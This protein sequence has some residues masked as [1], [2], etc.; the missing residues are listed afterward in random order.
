MRSLM[1]MAA[2]AAA[3]LLVAAGCGGM[4]AYEEANQGANGT[5][6]EEEVQVGQETQ[7]L[8]SGWPVPS[9]SPLARST[10]AL[11]NCTGVIVGKRDVITAAHCR[12]AAGT[13]VMFY[14]GPE[15]TGTT[16]VARWVSFRPGVNPASGDYTDSNGKF[17]DIAYL[18]L[19][20]D[21]PAGT[22]PARLPLSYPGNNAYGYRVGVGLHRGYNPTRTMHYD[23]GRTYSSHINDGHF[24]LNESDTNNGDSGG[25]FY[26]WASNGASW[27]FEVQGVLYGKVWE[28][29]YRN[30]YTSTRHH[31]S[32]LN[33]L[34]YWDWTNYVIW[35]TGEMRHFGTVLQTMYLP[36]EDR[37]ICALACRQRSD[38]LG[39]NYRRRS[40]NDMCQ[41]M[42]RITYTGP[43]RGY[44]AADHRF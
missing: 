28:W 41:L 10:V 6:E 36:D 11:P 24:L 13:T 42:S 20:A 9:G 32:W 12:P 1:Q 21:I 25:P 44:W 37:N 18:R 33:Y 29:A 43:Y 22:R 3:I 27:A 2:G 23:T 38:C 5:N 14:T 15:P 40:G 17:A 35:R 30:K 7:P 19:D 16:R 31:L 39:V 34:L 8:Q 4:E 26:I